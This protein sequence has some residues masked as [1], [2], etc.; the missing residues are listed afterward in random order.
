[1]YRFV[2]T[3]TVLAAVGVLLAGDA[4]AQTDEFE[5]P[6]VKLKPDRPIKAK[7]IPPTPDEREVQPPEEPAPP[8][9]PPPA[10]KE[11]EP[12]EPKA[13]V[14]PPEPVLPKPAPTPPAEVKPAPVPLK[15]EKPTES[16]PP[17]PA[18]LPMPKPITEPPETAPETIALP[19][20]EAPPPVMPPT[21]KPEPRPTDVQ[22][23]AIEA[24]VTPTVQP[25]LS[26]MGEVGLVEAV[27]MARKQYERS[28]E[29]LRV[30]YQNRGNNTKT[31][32]VE[33]EIQGFGNVPKVRYLIA[34]ELAGPNLKPTQN[35][36][37]ADQLYAE[38][39]NYKDYP[40]FPPGKKDYLKTALEKFRTIIEKY[41]QSDKID[42]AAFCMG[43]IYGGWYFQDYARAVQSY[44]RCWQ[45][46]PTTEHP[47]RFNAAKIFD[48]KL[49]NR[50][51][52]VELYNEVLAKSQNEDIVRQAQE[53][54]RALTG[55]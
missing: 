50:A 9:E 23:R 4:L 16:E 47:A 20:R 31:E 53:R 26:G 32:W 43:E 2:L 18:D 7:P 15:P 39:L 46:N 45:W 10:P 51:K 5:L 3:A 1:M 11:E 41:P 52:A 44:E 36:E 54:I 19:E 37:A 28:L 22:S 17:T 49:K 38:G 33:S 24:Q 55:R 25:D 13:P 27:A 8:P 30:Y 14:T 12:E 6:P 35:I 21:E 48:E 40:A 34:A 29:A 42:D